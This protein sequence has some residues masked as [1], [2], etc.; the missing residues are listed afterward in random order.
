MTKLVENNLHGMAN[1]ADDRVFATVFSK[2]KEGT[3]VAF[4]DIEKQMWFTGYIQSIFE[5]NGKYNKTDKYS[6]S[7][8]L[9]VPIE[10]QWYNDDDKT[11]YYYD[12]ICAVTILENGC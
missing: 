2:C 5:P 1:I 12:D 10:P 8:V 3:I 6:I 4:K 9:N 11:V 7:I